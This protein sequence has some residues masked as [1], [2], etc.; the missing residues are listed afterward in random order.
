VRFLVRTP[1]TGVIVKEFER[2][3]ERLLHFFVIGHDLRYFAHLHP[4]LHDDGTFEQRI[5]LPQA[6]AYR[7]IADFLPTGGAPQLLQKSVATAG[8]RGPLLPRGAPAPDL[9]DKVID[10]VRVALATPQPVGGLQQLVTFDLEDAATRKPIEDLEP[11]LGAAGHLLILSADLQD[12]AHSHPIAEIS[13]RL[14]PRVVFQVLFP[15]AGT[16]RMW[17]QFQRKGA[18]LTAPFTITARPRNQVFGR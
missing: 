14:G 5:V 7:L 17:A 12:A 9:G 1:E 16:Y 13:T 8:Y 4:V 10:G 6:G 15:R 11:F 3:H 2:V 18:V